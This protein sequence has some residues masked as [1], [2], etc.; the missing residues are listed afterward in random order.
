MPTIPLNARLTLRLS[1]PKRLSKTKA[2]IKEDKAPVIPAATAETETDNTEQG[3]ETSAQTTDTAVQDNAAAS[4]QRRGRRGRFDRRRGR[5]N[6]GRPTAE[7]AA[8]KEHQEAVILYN[9]H[10]DIT[11]PATAAEA[12]PEK[13]VLYNSHEDITPPATA[14]EA[15][16]EKKGKA[17]WWKKLIKG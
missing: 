16:P 4:R 10:E 5:G 2:V 14:A 3:E 12:E 7:N 13:K 1:A 11:P 15:E 9:S 6:T 17:A 8:P